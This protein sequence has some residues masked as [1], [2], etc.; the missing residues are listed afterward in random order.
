MSIL[1]TSALWSSL[2][3]EPEH[4]EDAASGRRLRPAVLRDMVTRIAATPDIWADYVRFDFYERH[5]VRLHFDDDFDVWLICWE[6]GQETL[7]HDHGGSVG[8]FAV[9]RGALFEDYG[10]R[11]GSTLRTRE[12]TTGESSAFGAEYLHNVV[13]VSATPAVSIHAYSLPLRAMNFFCWLPSG[14]RHLREIRCDTPEPD[15][16]A[17]EADAA[18]M[19][20]EVRA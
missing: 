13:N 20:A 8:S 15:T 7:L 10:D 17:L 2:R 16:T 12:L 1:S 11:R 5:A 14:P 6:F 18:R 9:A 4:F 19:R 3:P